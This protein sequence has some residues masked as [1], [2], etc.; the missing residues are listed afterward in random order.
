VWD[1]EID[2]AFQSMKTYFAR[3]PKI[4]SLVQGKMLLLY[5]AISKQA[6]SMVLVVRRAKQQILV[7]Y[8]S[9]IIT[10][11]EL[12]YPLIEKFAYTLV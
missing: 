8:M 7:Y 4:V 9:H 10:G 2:K 6:V 5:L 3:L 1:K 12:K 11:A